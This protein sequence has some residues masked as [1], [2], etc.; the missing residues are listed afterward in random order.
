MKTNSRAAAKQS[1]PAATSASAN[2]APHEGKPRGW[3]SLFLALSAAGALAASFAPWNIWPLAILGCAL[4][5]LALLRHSYG[6]SALLA[7][8]S[9]TAFFALHFPWI[10]TATSLSGSFL[11]LAGIEALAW[12]G[13][14]LFFTFVRHTWKRPLPL[15]ITAASFW[16]AFEALRASFPWSGMPWGELAYSQVNSPLGRLAPWGS[17]FLVAFAVVFLGALLAFAL[18][19]LARGSA[20]RSIFLIVPAGLALALSAFVPCGQPAEDYLTVALVQGEVPRESDIPDFDERSL[21]VT[22]NLARLTREILVASRGEKPDV[23]L[24]P[25]SASDRDI[26]TDNEVQAVVNSLLKDFGV[27]IILGTQEYVGD[28]RYNDAVLWQGRGEVAARYSKQ[29][30]VPFGEYLPERQLFDKY[31]PGVEA[32]AI[33]MK[34]GQKPAWIDF[35]RTDD[36]ALR[37]ATP[38]CFEIAFG[39]IVTQAVRDGAG[40]I[41]VPTNNASFG[42]SAQSAQQFDM[43]RFRAMETGRAVV[44]V[45]NVGPSGVIESNGVVRVKT[46]HFES[47]AHIVRVPISSGIT[48][49]TRMWP[50][51]SL[52]SYSCAGLIFVLA[53]ASRI[54]RRSNAGADRDPNL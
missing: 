20:A 28:Y 27:P 37:I 32:I 47:A 52:L 21:A 33:D 29:R 15:A 43:A 34:A 46:A 6:G 36:S 44:E 54:R 30:P 1:V 12:V 26:R 11:A 9:G 23:I 3:F 48:F 2:A 53:I 16:V 13:F 7:F 18:R 49:A 5:I 31:L 42:T 40:V 38:I 14:A 19:A 24:W 50:A 51:L 8:L 10:D 45:A 17:T 39:D 4:L 41:V 25:E 35:P 22:K